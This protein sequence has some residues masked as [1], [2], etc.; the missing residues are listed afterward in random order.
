[1]SLLRSLLFVPGNNTRMLEKS[2]GLNPDAIIPDLEDSVPQKEK[3]V[4]RDILSSLIPKL[5]KANKQVF[6]RVNS[7]ESSLIEPDLEAV[8]SPGI[9]GI[10]IG[11]V[12]SSK[13]VLLISSIIDRIEKKQ[14]I[15]ENM[16]QLIPWIESPKAIINA[17]E[18]YISSPR[19]VAVAFGAE[20]YSHEMEIERTVEGKEIWYARNQ[21]SISSHAAKVL[22]QD[23]PYIHFQNKNGLKK[24]C[25]ISKAIGFTGKFAI[26]PSQIDTIHEVFRIT[27]E[28]IIWATRILEQME[29]SETRGIGAFGLDG[30]MVDAPIVKKAR[31]ILE[32]SKT[33][34]PSLE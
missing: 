9:S 5:I 1:M 11:K 22:T 28:Q 15:T 33:T 31:Q 21:V 18:I 17:Y 7:I 32:R 23:T 20:D 25:E 3:S 19:I 13:D 6:P 34:N 27:T 2:F 12:E 29:T 14:G 10:S 24:D 8:I 4:A 30:K 26:H 16:I